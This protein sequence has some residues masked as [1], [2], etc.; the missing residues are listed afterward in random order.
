MSAFTTRRFCLLGASALAMAATP[1]LAQSA[2]DDDR[3][4]IV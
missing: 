2:N 3:E 1:A 4:I